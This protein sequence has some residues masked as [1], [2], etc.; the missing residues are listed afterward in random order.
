M[1]WPLKHIHIAVSGFVLVAS[2]LSPLGLSTAF[3]APAPAPSQACPT[4][5][6]LQ[7]D[8]HTC[9]PGVSNQ[10]SPTACLFDK[11]IDP[12]IQLLSAAVGLVAVA[13]IIT[14]AIE[15]TSSGGEPQRVASAKKHISNAL[16]GVFA[17]ALLYGF[18][19]FLIPG[20]L[21]NGG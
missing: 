10:Q 9:C 12:L 3:A 19:Q 5:Q 20:G 2:L 16:I 13:A 11:Y 17:F 4:G 14:G 15:Y 21:F 7:T 8:G 1:K 6:T 18:L